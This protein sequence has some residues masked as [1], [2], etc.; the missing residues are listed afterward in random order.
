MTFVDIKQIQLLK[1]H[2]WIPGYKY[3]YSINQQGVV[4]SYYMHNTRKPGEITYRLKLLKG[5]KGK[6]RN[7]RVSLCNE[8]GIKDWNIKKL[9]ILTFKPELYS[10]KIYIKHIDR[11][12]NNVS[13]NNLEVSTM[14]EV[15]GFNKELSHKT[16]LSCE[17]RRALLS[18]QIGGYFC[19]RCSKFKDIDTFYK[20]QHRMI[21]CKDCTR[22]I[23][24][25][26]YY[27]KKK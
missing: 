8:Q 12:L 16:Q 11:D 10:E 18:R 6:K 20:I 15:F 5:H 1:G 2:T 24:R 27:K 23:R 21:K 17:T 13:L 22:R 19:A 4:I 25:E 14:H 7:L 9:L 26:D 3:K